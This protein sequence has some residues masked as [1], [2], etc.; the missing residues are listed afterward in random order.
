MSAKLAIFAVCLCVHAAASNIVNLDQLNAAID[1][2]PLKR[3]AFLSQA[4][5]DAVQTVL[6]DNVQVVICDGTNTLYPGC[7][8]TDE[9]IQLIK[10]GAILAG[11]ISG[12]PESQHADQ[13]NTFT[14]TV[15]SLR[16]MFMAPPHS[17]EMPHGTKTSA[18]SSYDLSR[19]V[20]AA[21]VTM[22]STGKDEQVRLANMPFEFMAVHTCRTDTPSLFEVPNSNA[23][24]GL[25]GQTLTNKIL[26]VGALGPYNWG[27]NDGN[28]NLNPPAGF[29]PDWLTEFC[30][31]FN[32][33]AGPDGNRYDASGTITCERTYK[34]GS[35]SV[36][37]D[38]FEGNTYVTE[39]YYTVD[40]WYTG[41]G[42]TC[43]TED[44][45]LPARLAIERE[46]C[47][48][49]NGG[50]NSSLAKTCKHPQSPRVL[51]FRLSCSTLGVDSTFMTKKEAATN[52]NVVVETDA[53]NVDALNSILG[54]SAN[55]RV[56]F[57]SQA[58]YD[59][60]QTVLSDQVQV[61]VC[62]GSNSDYPGCTSTSSMINH[63]LAGDFVGGLISGL[64]ESTYAQ[65]LNT[66]SSTVISLRAMFMAPPYSIEMPHGTSS[67]SLSSEDLSKAVDAAIVR[68]QSSG[69][70]EL[71]R[72]NNMPFEFMAVHTCK[73]DDPTK[74]LVPN[75]VDATG[76]LQ[77]TLQ[78]KELKIGALGPYDWGGNDG[79]YLLNP[80]VGFYPD[81]LTAFCQEFN[82]LAGPD[83]VQYGASG[84]IACTRV[85]QAGSAGVFKDLFNGVSYVTEPYYTVD[86]M[87]TG[88]SEPCNTSTA[89]SDC[90]VANLAS[91]YETC[92]N[93][94]CTFPSSP[95]TRHFRFSCSTLGVD[96]S[97]MVAKN[98]T[99][100][101]W[102]P[103]SNNDQTSAAV[104]RPIS[105][106]LMSVTAVLWA[107]YGI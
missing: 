49:A 3:V 12:L 100:A 69:K 7:D 94:K 26:K 91:G 27:G 107:Y 6:S 96:S 62:D 61:V 54:Q 86:A 68:V 76:L 66:F 71:A 83:G 101:G 77:T 22:Q 102:N 65:Y 4:N 84:T 30:K 98:F 5:Y 8:S 35:A 25:L 28:Y 29:Y 11:L 80:P 2:G 44:D 17:V 89:S 41:T 40:A 103:S 99:L 85:Y 70:D 19:A 36:F 31:T 45:C 72:K 15:I 23:A 37:A 67:V 1:A 82:N 59:A 14:S 60:V 79:N 74:F 75:S 51:H 63:I 50:T 53:S 88:T 78:N 56:A 16:A 57:L 95:R 55:K 24:T 73:A 10:D 39:P 32:A 33:L 52:Q 81:W 38:L 87:Y 18:L 105:Q 64:P 20:D 21:I 34:G 48:D 92:S 42:Q 43:Q 97:F 106:I 9:L 93:N 90:R 58:N 46:Q 47:L 104:G 13:L